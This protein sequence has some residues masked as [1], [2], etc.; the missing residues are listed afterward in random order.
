MCQ[1]CSLCGERFAYLA[2]SFDAGTGT[3]TSHCVNMTQLHTN[4]KTR[5]HRTNRSCVVSVMF[6]GRSPRESHPTT[7]TPAP[8]RFPSARFLVHTLSRPR[9][10]ARDRFTNRES[11]IP[12]SS[13]PCRLCLSRPAARLKRCLS[14]RARRCC[15]C[16]GK[17]GTIRPQS[18]A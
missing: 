17:W 6:R 4:C 15:S 14:A 12:F 9:R 2:L 3:S 18:S 13:P 7:T 5:Q 1:F 16:T 8:H 11:V 10:F